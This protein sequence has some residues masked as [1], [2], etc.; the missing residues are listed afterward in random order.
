[1]LKDKGSVVR[2][3]MKGVPVLEAASGISGGAPSTVLVM[4][5]FAVMERVEEILDGMVG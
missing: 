2:S 1:M 3:M 5:A 4:A